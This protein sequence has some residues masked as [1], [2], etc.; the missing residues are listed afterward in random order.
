MAPEPQEDECQP[1]S[2]RQRRL[3]AVHR[4]WWCWGCDSCRVG[5]QQ[6]CP[7]CGTRNKPRRH[8]PQRRA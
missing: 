2:N 5:P 1:L 4:S 6:K 3:D 7:V 8:K